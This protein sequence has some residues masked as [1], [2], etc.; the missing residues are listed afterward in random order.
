MTILQILKNQ[1]NCGVKAVTKF[2]I[3]GLLWLMFTLYDTISAFSD[4]KKLKDYS[5]K[6]F[7]CLCAVTFGLGFM[8]KHFWMDAYEFMFGAILLGYAYYMYNVRRITK[9]PNILDGILFVINYLITA[10]VMISFT[11]LLTLYLHYHLTFLN[12]TL[13]TIVSLLLTFLATF[14]LNKLLVKCTFE[15]YTPYYKLFIR[16]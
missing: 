5:L 14:Y 3:A 11:M 16:N 7:V 15:L 13:Q 10:S 6:Y 8:A 12:S 1:L 9:T 2:I 4:A